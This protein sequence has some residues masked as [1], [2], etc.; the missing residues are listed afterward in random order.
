MENRGPGAFL[1]DIFPGK[2]NVKPVDPANFCTL[3]Y[4][5]PWLTKEEIF[6]RFEGMASVSPDVFRMLQTMNS[7]THFAI[8]GV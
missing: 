7:S 3:E 1:A 5:K 6:S 8:V 4:L 2:K